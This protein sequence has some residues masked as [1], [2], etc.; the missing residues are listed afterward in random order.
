MQIRQLEY[1]ISVSET[2]NFT[3]TAKRFFVTQA[4]VSQ[5]IRALE[6]EL[7][8][9]LFERTNRRVALTAAG[10]S[11]LE[12][13]RAIVQRTGD[14]VRRAKETNAGLTA[15]LRVGF[16]KGF[17]KTRLSE[18][19]YDF[20]I[21][22]PNVRLSLERENVSELYDGLL[23]NRYDVVF[24]LLFSER[25]IP[26]DISCHVLRNYPLLAVF[27]PN[28]PLA[29]RTA[30]SRGDLRGY[31]L[32][33]IKRDAKYGETESIHRIFLNSGYFPEIS[34]VSAD[35]ETSLLAVS[36]GLGYA[37]L[38]A[39][40]AENLS[41]KSNAVAI[42]IRGEE[43]LLTVVTAW[44]KENRDPATELFLARLRETAF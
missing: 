31:P 32:V 42:P 12:D 15:T 5:Q 38:P 26:D 7:G 43:N 11:F 40:V 21:E 36:A 25:S 9:A 8:F 2:L 24:N 13:A 37:L 41:G 39:Y 1:F 4:A 34:F 27:P 3:N 35:I 28:H 14:A 17:E 20:H 30:V 6:D 19:L 18:A 10:R 33:D 44:R 29:H 16:V 23:D 22:Y